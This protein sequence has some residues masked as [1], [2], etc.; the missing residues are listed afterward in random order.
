MLSDPLRLAYLEA[1][2]VP[3]W[4]RRVLSQSGAGQ[5]TPSDTVTPAVGIPAE[6]EL[7]VNIPTMDWD[8]LAGAVAACRKCGLAET[9]TQAV[10]GVGAREAPWMVVG[11]APGADEDRQG[12]PFVGRAGQLLTA[13]LLAAGFPRQQ[14][15]IAN[16]LK[17]RP[18]ANRDPRE[19]EVEA[20]SAYLLRQ[21]ELVRPRLILAVGRIAAQHLLGTQAP[22]GKL[23][24][25]I[26]VHEPS[27][28]PL[29]VTYHP[30][31]LLRSPGQK[32]RAWEDLKLAMA[33][34]G[35]SP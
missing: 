3:V 31:Y 33:T 14:V 11:E 8:H 1:L 35:V 26:H 27:G 5:D 19:N 28:I 20:C 17:C 21:I 16:V 9:R 34:S 15:Y 30:A 10:F 23:R 29:V 22:L 18:P 6:A 4:V 25:R 32:A 7:G 12:E 2:G 24:G 13:M